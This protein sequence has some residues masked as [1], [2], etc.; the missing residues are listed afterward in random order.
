[1]NPP[2]PRVRW[3]RLIGL[4]VLV[5][6]VLPVGGQHVVARMEYAG[7][8][9][10][11]P[12]WQARARAA[13]LPLEWADL[14]PSVPAEENAAPT[15]EL[16][17]AEYDKVPEEVK[18]DL[19]PMAGTSLDFRR[20]AL[21]KMATVLSLL[22]KAV[23]FPHCLFERDPEDPFD[24]NISVGSLKLLGRL[25][26]A[27]AEVEAYDG[28]MDSA[29]E[30]LRVAAVVGRHLAE[31]PAYGA[32]S[33]QVS[34]E[35]TISLS[36]SSVLSAPELTR[37][38]LDHARS[39]LGERQGGPLTGLKGELV[40]RYRI[41]EALD[42]YFEQPSFDSWDGIVATFSAPE[43]E[44]YDRR[45]FRP[46]LQSSEMV[47]K[48][49]RARLL[50]RWVPFF[51]KAPKDP[52]AVDRLAQEL[53]HLGDAVR[54][55]THRIDAAER[56]LWHFFFDAGQS[57]KSQIAVR[58]L[59]H[60]AVDVLEFR[61]RT[62]RY[63]ATLDEV[64]EPRADPFDLQPLRYRTTSDGF[65]VYSIGKDGVDDK[66]TLRSKTQRTFDILFEIPYRRR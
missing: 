12:A 4:A 34:L 11:L 15:Y 62:G 19:F 43:D 49:Y 54:G 55:G 6:V 1:M 7:D 44:N 5:A 41:Y 47:K 24:S 16:A 38:H 37:E 25:A 23:A 51:E 45:P 53:G 9:A 39:V 30:W 66:G 13:G 27:N 64:G 22:Q 48:A 63:P 46:F 8:A 10:T 40:Q 17:I 32:W 42:A 59:A 26:C 52:E 29:L 56:Q 35:H 2:R 61:Q 50:S 18:Q 36:L 28:R 65:V 14:D 31:E 58:R 33:G 3:A 60:Q 57:A 20:R 21:G